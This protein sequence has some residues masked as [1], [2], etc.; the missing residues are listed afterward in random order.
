MSDLGII[1]FE[2]D[3]PAGTEFETWEEIDPASLLAGTP[4]QRGHYYHELPE[5]G[6]CA[7]GCAR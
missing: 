1:R 7:G 3:G 4:V 5:L 2:P 6:Y